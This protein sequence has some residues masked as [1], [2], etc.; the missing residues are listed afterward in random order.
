MKQLRVGFVGSGSYIKGMGF[1][2]VQV[3]DQT[4]PWYLSYAD[5]IARPQKTF[6]KGPAVVTTHGTRVYYY[7]E[8]NMWI[9]LTVSQ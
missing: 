4:R 3:Y 5:S 6:P 2:S 9:D 7:T 1:D 8:L